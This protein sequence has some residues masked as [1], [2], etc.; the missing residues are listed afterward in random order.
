MSNIL[1]IL[2]IKS[3]QVDTNLFNVTAVNRGSDPY[4]VEFIQPYFTEIN[5][6]IEILSLDKIN[7]D[8]KW[9]INVDI[10]MWNWAD[11]R[12]NIFESFGK[13]ILNELTHGN[14]YLIL[15]HQC[16]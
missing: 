9:I 1:Q 16:E 14:A 10:N 4:W 6:G 11:Y 3:I 7:K 8:K 5:V 12:T 13:S 2:D 15:N